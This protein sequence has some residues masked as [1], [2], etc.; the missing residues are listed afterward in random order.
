MRKIPLSSGLLTFLEDLE[1][2]EAALSADEDA[3]DLAP[4]FQAE[5][6]VWEAVFKKERAGRRG[7]VRAEA[8]VAVRNA[9]LD[10]RT[11]RFGAAVLA[12]AGGNRKSSFFR[13][14]F[15]VAPS[16]L[17]RRPLRKQCEDTLHL[18]LAELAKLDPAHPLQGHADPLKT[19]AETAL[20]ALDDRNKAKADRS[21]RNNDVDEWKEGVNTLRLS[22]YAE[23]LKITADKGHGRAWADS[24]F[25]SDPGEPAAEEPTAPPPAGEPSTP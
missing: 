8:L 24:F 18:V 12:E 10:D 21:V 15:S 4:A 3:K 19:L 14:F 7:V 22:T 16:Q 25:Q 5:I 1:F 17:V 13:R 2:T 11:T 9:Q 23:L 6:D 20:Q